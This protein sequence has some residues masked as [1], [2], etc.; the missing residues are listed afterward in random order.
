[1]QRE[2]NE[3]RQEL[4]AK[5]ESLRCVARFT[6]WCRS[7]RVCIRQKPGEP[8]GRTRITGRVPGLMAHGCPNLIDICGRHVYP[9]SVRR[10]SLSVHSARFWT[11]YCATLL[12]DNPLTF[13]TSL[14]AFLVACRVVLKHNHI[15]FFSECNSGRG[16][17]GMRQVAFPVKAHIQPPTS[18]TGDVLS[19][20]IICYRPRSRPRRSARRQGLLRRAACPLASCSPCSA[21]TGLYPACLS[22]C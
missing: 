10:Y 18:L 11:V 3:K 21:S 16:V 12:P 13:L 1:V 19:A 17:N 5:E 20:C 15:F 14:P 2:I 8:T 7:L 9:T 22:D 6:G 4:L